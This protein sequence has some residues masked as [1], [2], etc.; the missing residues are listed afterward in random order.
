MCNRTLA[1]VLKLR[2]A[3]APLQQQQADV[4]MLLEH[5][6]YAAYMHAQHA[7]FAQLFDTAIAIKRL[8]AVQTQHPGW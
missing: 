7:N 4:R 3:P 5:A 2:Q 1:T 6:E 8:A